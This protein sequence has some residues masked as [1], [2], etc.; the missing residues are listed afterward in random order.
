MTETVLVVGTETA[1]VSATDTIVVLS[2][3]MGPPGEGA[4]ISSDIDNRLTRGTDLGLFV[5][6]IYIDPL[7][8]YILA[9]A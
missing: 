8:Y 1:V 5:P 3:Q 9:K 7:A 2:G 6:E 4:A